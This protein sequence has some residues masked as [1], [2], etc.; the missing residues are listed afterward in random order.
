MCTNMCTNNG[1]AVVIEL[2]NVTTLGHKKSYQ[3]YKFI[4]VWDAQVAKVCS[5]ADKIVCREG[6]L[7][8][9]DE[10]DCT[11]C[12]DLRVNRCKGLATITC[13]YH[14]P[15]WDG[16]NL[17]L[18][19]DKTALPPSGSGGIQQCDVR[20]QLQV[21]FFR[22]RTREERW[23]WWYVTRLYVTRVCFA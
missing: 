4:L 2:K 7:I 5:V 3:P 13:P 17:E 23:E 20:L 6:A 10:I 14:S 12:P 16:E 15:E 11:S 18:E 22:Y 1:K 8:N 19:M 9:W 21:S